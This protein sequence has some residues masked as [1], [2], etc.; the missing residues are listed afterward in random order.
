MQDRV[1]VDAVEVAGRISKR[2]EEIRLT[3]SRKSAR[4]SNSDTDFSL[5]ADFNIVQQRRLLAEA[6]PGRRRLHSTSDLPDCNTVREETPGI[7]S[8]SNNSWVS[9][10]I[11]ILLGFISLS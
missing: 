10:F 4:L 11:F 3:E 5:L 8:D 6:G 9:I 1:E 2:L 7:K